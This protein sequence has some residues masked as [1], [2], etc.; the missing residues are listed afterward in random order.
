VDDDAIDLS[1]ETLTRAVL[2]RTGSDRAFD[3][4]DG[5]FWIDCTSTD[6]I[7]SWYSQLFALW[8]VGV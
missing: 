8:S 4:L 5:F 6:E 7:A 2:A 3:Y 1:G